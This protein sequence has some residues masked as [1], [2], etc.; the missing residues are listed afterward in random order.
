MQNMQR[1]NLHLS[2]MLKKKFLI[3]TIV[4]HFINKCRLIA[5]EIDALASI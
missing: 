3:S 2:D 5:I 1:D 4:E